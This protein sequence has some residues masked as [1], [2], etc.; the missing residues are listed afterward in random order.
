MLDQLIGFSIRH[1]FIVM[2]LVLGLMAWGSYALLR[3]P[4]DAVPDITNNQVQV[5][6]VSPALTPQEIERFV[7]M[8]IELALANLPKVEQVRSISK[9]GLSIVTVVFE[10]GAD[11]L[12]ARQLV[13]EQLKI[14]ETQIP[15]TIGKPELMPITTGLGEIYQYT[16]VPKKGYEDK[17]SATDIRSIQDW[18]IKRQLSGI[19]GVI[20]IS[21]FGGFVKQYEIA[22]KPD[23]LRNYDLSINE[24]F[25]AIAADNQNAGGSYIEKNHR[26]YYIRTEALYKNIEE[27]ENTL[28][29]NRD[30]KPIFIKDI[31]EVRIGHAPR[32]GA[33]TQDGKGEAVGGIVLMLKG[34]NS[35]QVVQNVKERVAKVQKTLPEGLEI[36]PYLER[37][38]LIDRAIATVSQNLIE[39][40]LIVIFVLVI[41]LGNFR[42]GLVVASVIPLSMLFALGM[43][44]VFNVSANLMSLGA[45]DFGLIVD[46]SVI[47][48][49]NMVHH[50]HKHYLGKKLTQD[51]MN[52]AVYKASLDI[53]QS[54]SFGEIIILM[55]Y[56]PILSLVGIEGKMFAPM[57]QT[58]IFAIIGAFILSLTYVPMISAVMLSKKVADHVTFSDKMII[59][60][61]KLYAPILEKALQLRALVMALTLGI[62]SLS[63]W[64]FM[65]MGGEFIPTLEEGDLAMQIVLPAGSS[66]EESVKTSVEAEKILMK[67][68][69][70]V[71]GV[72]AKIGTAEIPT[73]PMSIEDTDVMILL[74]PKKEWTTTDDREILAEK[75]KEKLSVLSYASFEFSQ[76]IELRFNELITGA[77][78]D[79]AIKIFGEDLDILHSKAKEAEALI[80]NVEGIG[81]LRVEQTTGLP[82]VVIKPKR[83]KLAQHGLTVQEINQTIETAF[84]GSVAS[85]FFEGEKRFDLIVRFDNGNRNKVEDVENLYIHLPNGFQMPLKELAEVSLEENA[86][87]ISRE[88][89]RRRITVGINVRNR[90]VESLVGEISSIL[91]AKLNLPA[92]YEV[93]Y[94]GQF[95]NLQAAK[96]RLMIAVPAALFMIFALLYLTFGSLQQAILIFT[97]VPLSAIGGIWALWLRDM[98]FSISAGVGFIALFG[99]AVLNGIVLIGH[100]NT[101]KKEGLPIVDRI[102]NGAQDR[103]R[104]VLMTAM[105]AALGFLPMAISTAA[106]A[107]VQKPLATVVIGGLVTATFLTLFVLPVLYK[108]FTKEKDESI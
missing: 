66:L 71:R 65:Q 107:E 15:S 98:P 73:D 69:P 92:G 35:Y 105:T 97:A 8:P 91:T 60:L 51:E 76:P 61:Q 74:K 84:A 25:S 88:N 41:L 29:I 18:Q 44:Y 93:H 86:A 62:F 9:F 11:L 63:I 58:V 102:M 21:S 68:F 3:L 27:I 79:I 90:D 28:L 2:I 49:E 75:M 89:T 83:D 12:H 36:V 56:L 77:K 4:L 54:A 50:L 32:L 13:G 1:K 16:L 85:Q 14:A 34:A 33:M 5:V 82:Q 48:V 95:E 104:A 100:F 17:F 10:D 23:V 19:K 22:V 6:L 96:A 94:G 38:D 55:V 43:M 67:N 20:E 78:S 59:F 80:K 87:M 57:A 47:I 39:G 46:G 99:V 70:E 30:G 26:R 64:I 7:T 24:V 42:A 108:T 103:L 101:L 45:I 31:A 106:G 72:V 53:R 52:G 40:G 81:D 37:T